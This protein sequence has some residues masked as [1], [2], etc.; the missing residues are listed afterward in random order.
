MLETKCEGVEE[1]TKVIIEFEYDT[2]G[3]EEMDDAEKFATIEDYLN[4]CADDTNSD[5]KI[6]SIEIKNN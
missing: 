3:F 4:S 5:I 1:M 2:F 6:K